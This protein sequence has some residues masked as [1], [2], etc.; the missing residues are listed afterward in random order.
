MTLLI[1]AID[2]GTT[3]VK[4]VLYDES[5]RALAVEREPMRY[6]RDG[7]RVEFDADAVMGVVLR[8]VR[9]CAER[10]GA[11]ADQDA[12]IVVT[13]Q[14]ESFVLVDDAGR[15]LAPG[16]SWMDERSAAEAAEIAAEFDAVA[17]FEIT[18]ESSAVPTW[19]ATKLRW[20]ARHR[21]QLIADTDRVLMIKDFVLLAL[22]GRAVGEESTRGF[23]YLYDVGN[24]TYW[25]EMVEFCGIRLDMLPELV[26]AGTDVGALLPELTAQLP[27]AAS[28]IV[29]AGALDHFCAMVGTSSYRA[30]AADVSAGTVLSISALA[31]DWHFEPTSG[32]SFHSGVRQGDIVLF[33]C[34]D[35][36]GVALS[37]FHSAV[38]GDALSYDELE[39]QLPTRDRLA[40][41][42]FLP[43]LTGVNPP[44]FD[45][46]ARGAFLGLRLQ[47]DRIDLALAV[48]EGIAHLL[49]RNIDDLAT[50]EGMQLGE[51]ASAGGGTMSRF[52]NQLKA[53]ATGLPLRVPEEPEAA[54]RGAAILAL[55]AAGVIADIDDTGALH[56]P[57]E[58]VYLPS[59]DGARD[60]RYGAFVDALHTLF[61]AQARTN[62]TEIGK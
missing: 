31:K 50:H 10:A 12:R 54:C 24:R 21:P 46:E 45:P 43:Y 11:S 56:Q 15:P 1:Y 23:T 59:N 18:G 14:A 42:L 62:P 2:L 25:R 47:H 13:G 20:L 7:D 3:N 33:T 38:A 49:R 36:G 39:G 19:P 55:V 53:D 40:A 58:T 44:D 35:S 17:A 32:V 6:E 37:W 61:G 9:A 34:A 8:L 29:N 16:I 27:P 52:W 26:P 28:Y 4:V 5:L 22:T 57:H 41:P 60:I 30:G 51:L 48:M